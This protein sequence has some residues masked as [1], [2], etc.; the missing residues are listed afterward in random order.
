MVQGL[1]IRADCL[2]EVLRLLKIYLPE[3]EIWAFGSR[4]RGTAIETSDL[5]L[6]A[7]HPKELNQYQPGAFWDL[8]EAFSDSNLPFLV[9][10][11]DWATIPK[12]FQQEISKKYVI[13]QTPV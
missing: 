3:A 7:R 2:Q 9:D 5:D 11:L 4:V 12:S 8:K 6:V 1:D 10:I 13:L